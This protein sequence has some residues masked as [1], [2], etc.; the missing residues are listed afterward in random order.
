M[1]RS[2]LLA[3]AATLALAAPAH[4]NNI[5]SVAALNSDVD[6]TPP[7]DPLVSILV[8]DYSGVERIIFPVL[9][10]SGRYDVQMGHQDV[11]I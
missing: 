11:L 3:T 6:G 5:G 10:V 1:K 4:A 9:G 7:V 8:R 2:I